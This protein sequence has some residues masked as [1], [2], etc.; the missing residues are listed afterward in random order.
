MH[1]KAATVRDKGGLFQIEDLE[2]DDPR[3][4]EV[5]VRIAGCG[6]CHT[7][8][9]AR[10]GMTP[11]PLP[12][13]LGHEGSGVVEQVG[14]L[15]RKVEP[16]DHVVLTFSSCGF[17]PNCKKG[18]PSL[19]AVGFP[20]NFFGTRADGSHTTRKNGDVVNASFFGQSS[21]AS[22]ALANQQ[23]V[24]K[25]PKDIPLEILGPLGCGIQTGAG[26]VIN[27][28]QTR[29]GSSLA[30]F[31]TGSV[32]MA[33]VMAAVV[34]GCTKIIA[35]DIKEERLKLARDLGATHVINPGL[36][37]PVEELLKLTGTG[38]NYSLDCTGAPL[39]VRQ[40]VDALAMGGTCG[41]I[42]IS[43]PGTDMN[44]DIVNMLCG[45]SVTGIMG[46][47][48]IPDIFIPQLIDLYA[49][50]RFPF[51]KILRFYQLDEI[52]KAVEDSESGRTVKAVLRP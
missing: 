48:A 10:Q 36:A 12:M 27:V 4:D 43:P 41:L 21:F 39:V 22:Y 29:P 34:C 50:G 18:L 33:A 46:G 51:D 24:V 25:V 7:D 23:N 19:C 17:C 20:L 40:A 38:V 47:N 37:N 30:V 31:G 32:G 13:V 44:L 45:R 9:A 26:G 8:L 15:V 16:G 14:P 42:G 1:I 6:L 28:L 2:L 49:Q 52:N 11:A 3:G 35:V 5:L